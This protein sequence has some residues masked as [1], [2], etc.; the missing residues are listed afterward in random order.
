MNGLPNKLGILSNFIDKHKLNII[1]VSES[2]LTSLLS[3]SFISIPGYEIVRS[4]VKGRVPKHGVCAYVHRDLLVDQVTTPA[5]NV[6]CFRLLKF[7]VYVVIVYRPPSYSDDQNDKL[8]SSLDTLFRDREVIIM[9]DFNLPSVSW[10]SDTGSPANSGSSTD[11]KFL[12]LFRLSGLIQWVTQPT[13]PR[14]G[15]TLDLL[16]TTEHDRV[17]DVCVEP[18]LPGCD[19]CPFLYDYVFEDDASSAHSQEPVL[20]DR[21]LWHKGNYSRISEALSHVDWDFE[22]AHLSTSDLYHRFVHI[23][24]DIVKDYIPLKPLQP[25]SRPVPWKVTPPGGLIRDRQ[26]AW[27]SYKDVRHRLGRRSDA[28]FEAYSRFTHLNRQCKYFAVRS[29]ADY[30]AGLIDVWRENPKLFHSYVRSKK[31]AAVTVGPLKLTDGQLSGDPALMS[32]CLA[33]SFSSV[34]CSRIPAYQE[35]H[36]LHDALLSDL[37][38]CV[39]EVHALLCGLDGNSAMGPDLLHP[40]LL[41]KCA[42]VLAYPMHVLFTRSLSQGCVPKLWKESVIVPIFKK[43]N[44]YEPLNYRPIS[45]TS[46]PCKM[47][48]RLICM[49]IY[50]YLDEHSILSDHQFGFRSGRSTVDQLLLVY[51]EV[52]QSVDN[53]KS[54]DVILFDYSKAFDVVNHD[55]LLTKLHL[56]GIN[57]QILD[58]I[59]SFLTGRSLQVSVMGQ[60]SSPR[61]VLSGVPQGSVLGPLLFLV[62]I[63]HIASQLSCKYKIFADDLKIYACTDKS[64]TVM[65]NASASVPALQSDIDTLFHTSES[66][67]LHIN[68]S[69][70]AVLRFSRSIQKHGDSPNDQYVLNGKCL[71]LVNSHRDLGVM[72]DTSLKFHEHIETV[73]HKASG[74]CHS[75]L[76]STVCRSPEFMVFLFKTHV[77]P[78]LEYGSCLWNTGYVEDSRKLERVQRRW[79]KR[80]ESLSELSYAERLSK[81]G[82]YSV[83]GR[84]TRADLIQYWK[85]LG[86]H[87]CVTPDSMFILSRNHVTRGHRL[88]VHLPRSNTD[89]RKRSFSR[90]CI[91]LWNSLPEWVVSAPDLTAFKRGLD[92]TIP[93][94]LTEYV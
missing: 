32:E 35:P 94:K 51:E 16:L 64:P 74:L 46:V 53:G 75:F 11:K 67:G 4:D 47:M 52:H 1:G 54:F 56:I 60:K 41:K 36:Q 20:Q 76:K 34:F 91:N 72:V 93:E 19:H 61:L 23:V 81:L 48:E 57:G 85:I 6:L 31:A 3:S 50:D 68:A 65:A 62:Y 37:R 82:L 45:L 43:G 63:N 18:P 58:W 7:N 44:R 59:S 90:R 84:L 22:F 42:S 17:G 5:E 21:L 27:Q 83:Q 9:G 71:P 10:N 14:S 24:M 77:R 69:K 79:T 2:H 26:Q 86:G 66:W 30:E 8:L 78:V 15:N 55:I 12:E 40:L 25:K 13:Y 73:S 92:A 39:S 70:C 28:A 29:Q 80:V 49:H 87:S 38:I 88:K 33:S 89:I